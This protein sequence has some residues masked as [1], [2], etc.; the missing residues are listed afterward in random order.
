MTRREQLRD[1]IRQCADEVGLREWSIRLKP[2]PPDN[3]CDAQVAVTED[4]HDAAIRVTDE[5]FEYDTPK[6]RRIVAHELLHVLTNGM[7]E[8]TSSLSPQ[9]PNAAWSVF[10]S[11]LNR[12]EELIVDSLSRVLERV[13]PYPPKWE[14]E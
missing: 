3:E 12:E 6:Q 4:Q 9:V 13:L 1:Y 5:F 11:L 7:L 14:D 10:W 2:E 8:V